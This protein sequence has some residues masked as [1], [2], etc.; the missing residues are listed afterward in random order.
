M[1]KLLPIVLVAV[2]CLTLAVGVFAACDSTQPLVGLIALHDEKSTYDKNFID[3]FKAACEAKGLT[4]KQYKIV[5]N[6]PEDEK[7]YNFAADLA[8]AGC[9]AIFADS[10]GHEAHILKAAKEFKD[11]QFCHAT[12]TNAVLETNKD[13]ANYHN[14]FASIYEARYL[15]GVAAGMK[16]QEMISGN[17]LTEKN[18]D[19]NGNYLIGYVGAYTYAEVI[20]GYTSFYLGVKS[21]VENV[22]MQVTFT[23]SW[24]DLA[25]EK[26]AAEKLIGNG[27]AL[28]SQHADSMGAPTACENAK[29]PNITYNI[30]TATQCIDTYV[31]AS[32]INWQPYFEMMIDNVLT[33]KEL[34]KDWT[35]TIKTGSVEIM[36]IGKA[37]AEGTQAKLDQ[38]KAGIL[39]G[40]V[41]VFDTSKFTVTVVSEGKN[42]KNVGAVVDEAGHV[43]SYKIKADGVNEADAIGNGQFNEST[44]RSAPY[45]DLQIDGIVLLDTV[46]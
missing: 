6:V 39:D 45:F 16:L 30:S 5:T 42:Q 38:V 35:G 3:A 23:G 2:L 9:K 12:G 13:V 22:T 8:D 46:Y 37:A 17:K 14:A 40:S 36:E 24:Y 34:P 20:S 10:F 18:I 11:V 32:R 44:L 43:T 21:V 26:A 25:D 7:C 33:G 41:K 19:E 31:I 28:V 27:C 4:D 15:A 29:V 1:K